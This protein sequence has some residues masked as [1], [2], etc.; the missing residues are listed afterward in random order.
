MKL[1]SNRPLLSQQ[2][3]Y[4]QNC[5]PTAYSQG[6]GVTDDAFGQGMQQLSVSDPASPMHAMSPPFVTNHM[7][8]SRSL[9]NSQ[10]LGAS[11]FDSNRLEPRSGIA[12][13]SPFIVS[14]LHGESMP[15]TSHGPRLS[16]PFETVL[17]FPP[18][19]KKRCHRK[20]KDAASANAKDGNVSV[21][22]SYNAEC[23]TDKVALGAEL[24]QPELFLG[25]P[26]SDGNVDQHYPQ[27][28]RNEMGNPFSRNRFAMPRP[29]FPATLET[30]LI[31]NFKPRSNV[32]DSIYRH[33]PVPKF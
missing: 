4:A 33:R 1:Q 13:T 28:F 19:A 20:R 29:S 5:S 32:S 16:G 9:Q 15:A 12:H 10:H 8:A 30:A 6:V 14:L 22:R 26:F 17:A 21:S 7:C 27:F 31:N 11:R 24:K 18:A 25:S 3:W 2:R 23:N